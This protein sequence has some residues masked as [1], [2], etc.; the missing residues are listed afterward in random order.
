MFGAATPHTVPHSYGD[1]ASDRGCS[2]G[3]RPS[4]KALALAGALLLAAAGQ[5]YG[6]S[7]LKVEVSGLRNYKG[8]VVIVL[9]AAADQT[10]HFPDHGRVQ[11]R[12]ESPNDTPCDFS[13]A[14]VCR[15]TV[16]SLQNLT[17][18]YTFRDVP[19]GDYAIFA[20]HDENNN[21]ILDRGFMGRPLEARGYSQVLPDDVSTLGAHIGFYR[22]RFALPAPKT[23]VVGLR[24]PPFRPR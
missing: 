21:G 22:A 14:S 1:G 13:K 12:D 9:W 15:R 3:L 4:I 8:R 6:A 7:D 11:L 2:E 19:E 20:F 5:A 17:V 24:Y 18:S 10:S 16:D 23:V